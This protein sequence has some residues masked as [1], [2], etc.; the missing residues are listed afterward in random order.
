MK[1]SRQK[2]IEAGDIQHVKKTVVG[3]VDLAHMIFTYKDKSVPGKALAVLL[4]LVAPARP[5]RC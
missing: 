2:K 3:S 4:G 5:T 1:K